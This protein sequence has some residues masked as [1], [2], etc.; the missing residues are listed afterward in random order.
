MVATFYKGTQIQGTLGPEQDGQE[1]PCCHESTMTHRMWQLVSGADLPSNALELGTF[2]PHYRQDSCQKNHLG[3][4][5]SPQ[6]PRED[7]FP[8]AGWTLR[9]T[10]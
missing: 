8:R 6:S 1:H 10:T 2:S 9:T 3:F 5:P 4:W 7:I